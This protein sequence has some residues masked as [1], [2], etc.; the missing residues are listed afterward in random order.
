MEGLGEKGGLVA[1]VV[2][3][4]E[5]LRSVGAVPVAAAPQVQTWSVVLD[6]LNNPAVQEVIRRILDRIF[7]T[8]Q[9]PGSQTAPNTNLLTGK[10]ILGFF[11]G[12]VSTLDD[13]MTMG[14]FKVWIRENRERLNQ[15]IDNALRSFKSQE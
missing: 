7:P 10:D 15:V 3:K 13:Q 4:E 2:G 6:F 11:E 5:L 1:T 8:R 14:Q 12:F 9:T